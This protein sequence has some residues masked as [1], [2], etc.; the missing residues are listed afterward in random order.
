MVV[1][2]K[3]VFLSIT[4]HSFY[5]LFFILTIKAL[6]HGIIWVV[7]SYSHDAS[8]GTVTLA[9]Q[10]HGSAVRIKIGNITVKH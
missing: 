5:F 1:Y 7:E 9:P 10:S 3:V 8:N 6:T 2:V 4:I